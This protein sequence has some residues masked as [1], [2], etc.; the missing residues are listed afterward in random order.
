MVYVE[1]AKTSDFAG[2]NIKSFSVMGKKIGVVKEAEN[3]FIAIEIACK[4]QGADLSKGKLRGDV[5]TCPRHGWQYNLKT[6]TCLNHDSPKLKKHD[7]VI[8]DHVIKVSLTPLKY[9]HGTTR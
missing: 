3:Q 6:G 9:T 8:E 2:T 4:H 5:V 1:L 7:V